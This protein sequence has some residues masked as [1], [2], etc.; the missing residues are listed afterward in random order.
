MQWKALDIDEDT[1]T[2][3]NARNFEPSELGDVKIRLLDGATWKYVG[4]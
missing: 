4:E 2:G 1:R 3:V